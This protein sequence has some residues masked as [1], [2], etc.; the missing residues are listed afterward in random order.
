M[1]DEKNFQLKIKMSTKRLIVLFLMILAPLTTFAPIGTTL[2]I[3]EAEMIDFWLPVWQAVK[4]I[5]SSNNSNA[6]NVIEG[7]FGC[8]QIR[9]EK[10]D[11]FNRATGN[12][13]S[14]VDCLNES[15]SYEVFRWHCVGYKVLNLAVKRWNGKGARAEV[16]W[17]KIQKQL[18]KQ[19]S[20]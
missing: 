3:M 11:D 8:G 9:Q 7:A 17:R 10:L 20:G 1:T 18:I 12:N 2:I 5:E 13:Y 16:Y 6:V 14:L 15:V 4:T 19:Q